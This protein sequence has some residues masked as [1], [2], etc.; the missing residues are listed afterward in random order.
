M[1]DENLGARCRATM[2]TPVANMLSRKPRISAI[3]V[4]GCAVFCGLLV[5]PLLVLGLPI[6][7]CLALWFSGYLDML[8]GEL[9]RVQGTASPVG[10]VVDIL[11]DR[12][13]E[14]AVLMGLLLQAP[15]ERGVIIALQF[16]AVLLC[17]SSFLV[18]GIFSVEDSEKSF[19]Y[20]PGLMERGEAFLF[21]TAMILWP[22]GF[23]VLGVVFTALVFWT[24]AVRVVQFHRSSQV[25]SRED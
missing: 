15:S 17:V 21:F 22:Q 8:D 10:A 4:T 19:H 3:T 13:V 2:V 9:A 7:A 24:A 5:M 11:A 23:V 16:S 14:S 25:I 20:S 1:L 12:V 18:V 6:W